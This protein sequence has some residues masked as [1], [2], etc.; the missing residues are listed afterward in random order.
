MEIR[1]KPGCVNVIL[2]KF[3]KEQRVWN[4]VKTFAQIQEAQE[5]KVATV[6]VGENTVSNREQ[7]GLG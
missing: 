4:S 3:A 6:H 7:S 2:L 1:R 5:G